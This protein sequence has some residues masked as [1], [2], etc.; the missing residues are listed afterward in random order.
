MSYLTKPGGTLYVAS[1]ENFKENTEKYIND[2][3]EVLNTYNATHDSIREDNNYSPSGKVK[4]YGEQSQ[5]AKEL[6]NSITEKYKK[7]LFSYKSTQHQRIAGATEKL[8]S[9]TMYEL[10]LLEKSGLKDDDLNPYVEKYKYIPLALRDLNRISRK[11]G[12]MELRLPAD[13]SE[14]LDSLIENV[15]ASIVEPLS[16]LD[17]QTNKEKFNSTGQSMAR[18]WVYQGELDR[19][20]NQYEKAINSDEE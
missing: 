19:A 3:M 20:F 10:Q 13:Q 4:M 15:E 6:I 17:P 9:E 8:N 18:D 11:N 14:A 5:S 16:N 2:I 1:D 12:G 7:N